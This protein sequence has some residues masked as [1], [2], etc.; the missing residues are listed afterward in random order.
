MQHPEEHPPTLTYLLL[1]AW[2]Y[3]LLVV[4]VAVFMMYVLKW[5]SQHWGL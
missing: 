4:A 5:F 1:I 3:L 2:S